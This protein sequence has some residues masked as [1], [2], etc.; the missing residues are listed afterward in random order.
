MARRWLGPLLRLFGRNWITLFGT[1]LTTVSGTAIIGF[2]IL[3]VFGLV[4]SPYI[5]LMALLVL[6]AVFIFGLLLIPLGAYLQKR[7]DRQAGVSPHDSSNKRFP[8]ID[9]NNPPLRRTVAGVAVLTIIN[10]LIIS[11]VS[12]HGVLYMDSPEFC[13]QVCHTVMDP[14]FTAYE[15]S[16]HSRVDCVECHIGPGAPWFVRSKLSGMGQLLAVTFNTYEH[17]IATP[18]RNLRPSQDT[19]EQCHWPKRFTGDRV[20]VLTRFSEDETNTA[21]KTVLILHIGGGS[22]STGGIH[23]WHIDPDRKTTYIAADERRQEISW[24]QVEEPDG[25]VTE[26]MADGIELTPE[27]I[28]AAPKRVMDC[29]DCHNRPTHIF[30]LP[31]TALDQSMAAGRIDSEIPFI[32][33]I[34]VEVLT[35]VGDSMGPSEQVGQRIR[36]Y[37]REN[38]RRLFDSRRQA[39]E[40]AIREIQDLYEQNVFPEMRVTWGT[41]PNNIG[42]QNFP[43][44]FR[45]HDGEHTSAEGESIQQDCATCHNLAA[46]DEKDP[47]VL[48]LLGVR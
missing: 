38:Y 20:K 8:T 30:Q 31:G 23:S 27:Q 17:P 1:S 40:R 48:S 3:G 7:W 47:E 16:P 36:Q 13:G 33:K 41:Y 29:I 39:L 6:P 46:W 34:G 14:E 26:Y 9:L 2:L 45:C 32:K 12:Y 28:A 18:V 22:D 24:I 11:T 43:G 21:L 15:N 10:V 4:D 44:C 37:Y 25:T 42:H 35:E 19:C 5:A